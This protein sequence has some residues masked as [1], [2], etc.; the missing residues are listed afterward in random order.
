[1]QQ[2]DVAIGRED[3]RV[4]RAALV[5]L[6]RSVGHVLKKVDAAHSP[7]LRQAIDD[8]WQRWKEDKNANAVFWDLIESE[9]NNVLKVYEFGYAEEDVE[10]EEV[11]PN[12][13]SLVHPNVLRYNRKSWIAQLMRKAA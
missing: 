7:A 8:R 9:R 3:F 5:A 13:T 10:I 4:S 6:F 11:R 2:A 1:L 12:G